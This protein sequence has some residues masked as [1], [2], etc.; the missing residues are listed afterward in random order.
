MILKQIEKGEYVD[1]ASLLPQTSIAR[2]SDDQYLGFSSD[3]NSIVLKSAVKSK[4]TNL[5]DWF[6]AWTLYMQATLSVKPQLHHKLFSYQKLFSNLT[7]KYTFEACYLYD[8]AHRKQLSSQELTSNVLQTIFW[9]KIDDEIHACFLRDSILPK[10]FHCK[11]TGHYANNC[12]S[13]H[14]ITSSSRPYSTGN[15]PYRFPSYSA[16]APQV[17][18]PSSSFRQQ[19]PLTPNTPIPTH[20]PSSNFRAQKNPVCFRYNSTGHCNKPPCQFQHICKKCHSPNH[21]EY[22]CHTFTGSTFRP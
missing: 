16:A 7:R 18:S 5:A 6:Y 9:D 12:P 8:V 3:T 15:H 19:T 4:V 17:S 1:F 20:P 14:S 11:S 22:L 10:C 21:P 2:V 13:K